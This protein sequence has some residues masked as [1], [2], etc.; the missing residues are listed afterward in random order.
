MTW[1]I[2][3]Y[4]HVYQVSCENVERFMSYE[5]R[6][7]FYDEA[8]NDDAKGSQLIAQLFYFKKQTS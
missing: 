5:V 3:S 1:Y 7:K 6:L 4:E 8:D 2:L